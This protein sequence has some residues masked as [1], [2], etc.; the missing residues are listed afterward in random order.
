M[1]TMTNYEYAGEM[2]ELCFS[3]SQACKV[4]EEKGLQDFYEAASD[5]FAQKRK[6]YS[7]DE[8]AMIIVK[9]QEEQ[10]EATAAYAKEL[11]NEA[12]NKI[13]KEIAV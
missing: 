6:N 5:G 12:A 11:R 7:V 9:S 13:D 8:A 3:I 1:T 10:L 2:Q 4:L